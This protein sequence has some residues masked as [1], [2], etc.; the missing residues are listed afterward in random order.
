MTRFPNLNDAQAHIRPTGSPLQAH[1]IGA[2]NQAVG[3]KGKNFLHV[4]TAIWS[5]R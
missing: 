3:S 1:S 4:L 5:C 2:M